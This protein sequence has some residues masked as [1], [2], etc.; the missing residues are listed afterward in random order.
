[1]VAGGAVTAGAKLQFTAATRKVDDTTTANNA[2]I[3]RAITP[4]SADG[5]II[6]V[7]LDF[8]LGVQAAG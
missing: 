7:E 3:G 2:F 6:Q 5:D 1:M 4:A 8:S